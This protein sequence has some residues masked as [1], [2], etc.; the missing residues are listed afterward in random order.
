MLS[1][2]PSD[3]PSKGILMKHLTATPD[4]SCVPEPFRP[5]IAKALDKNPNKRYGSMAEM[6]QAVEPIQLPQAIPIGVRVSAI[7]A[8]AAPPGLIL[9]PDP[10]LPKG[11]PIPQ[12]LQ[13]PP[14]PATPKAADK[15][16]L[17][18][19]RPVLPPTLRDRLTGLLGA[20]LAA[21][22]VAA[23]GLVPYGQIGRA[24]V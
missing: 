7:G 18:M 10:E 4:L 21:P 16:V 19:A 11:S 22:A 12:R 24:H 13:A 8:V 6:A 23:L 20:L 3:S 17:P 15:A 5:I 9:T 14:I 2:L 1:D